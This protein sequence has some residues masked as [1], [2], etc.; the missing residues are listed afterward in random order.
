MNSRFFSSVLNLALLGVKG[1][2]KVLPVKYL[3]VCLQASTKFAL[4]S[5]NPAQALDFFGTVGE[6]TEETPSHISKAAKLKET[7]K[8]AHLVG[9]DNIKEKHRKSEETTEI[10]R[11]TKKRRRSR[12]EGGQLIL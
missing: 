6:L 12:T 11:K 1:L 8:D 9:L 4:A 7:S 3:N 10:K 2:N 5:D